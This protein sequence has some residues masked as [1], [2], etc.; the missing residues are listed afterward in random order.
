[1]MPGNRRD[2]CGAKSGG[3]MHRQIRLKERYFCACLKTGAFLL[4]DNRKEN[5][6]H[7]KALH[8]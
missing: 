8:F 6:R 3:A 4:P 2:A 1:M 7:E 5:T